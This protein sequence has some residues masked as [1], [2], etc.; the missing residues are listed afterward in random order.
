MFQTL[1]YFLFVFI[2]DTEI[3]FGKLCILGFYKAYFRDF[4]KLTPKQIRNSKNLNIWNSLGNSYF[5][6]LFGWV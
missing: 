5:V 6:V 1:I 3:R 2:P 4:M